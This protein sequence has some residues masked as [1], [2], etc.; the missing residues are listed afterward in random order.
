MTTHYLIDH[1]FMV[2]EASGFAQMGH[3]LAF[4]PGTHDARLRITLY[5]E[6]REPEAFELTAPAGKSIETNYAHWPIEPNTRFALGVESDQPIACQST[7]GWNNSGN[8]YTPNAKTKTK[9]GVRESV[10]SYMA[11][12]QLGNEWF[13]PDGIVIDAPQRMYVRESEWALLL[14]PGDET[15][16]VRMALYYDDVSE[17]LLEVQ[18]RRLKWVYLDD[19]ARRNVHY[20]AHFQSDRPIAV[21]WLREVRWNDRSDLMGYWSVP[22]VMAPLS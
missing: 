22:C 10:K 11:I 7:V 8:D 5:F 4:N 2:D 20:G 16:Q 17:H 14:N 18:P 15:A 19:I 21:Q 6:D 13:L 9:D 3:L 12:T 1:E